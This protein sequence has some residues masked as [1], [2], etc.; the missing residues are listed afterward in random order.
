LFGNTSEALDRTELIVLITPKVV[1]N[2]QEAEQ[3]TEEIK[4]KMR[5]IAPLV[6]AS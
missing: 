6:P 4:R 1:Q 5:E 2:S 3:V